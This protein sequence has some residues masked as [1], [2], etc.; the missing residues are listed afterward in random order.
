MCIRDRAHRADYDAEVL[1]SIWQ[2]MLTKLTEDDQYLTHAALAELKL[3]QAALQYL[4]PAHATVYVKNKDGLRD[5]YKLVSVSHTEFSTD[6][7]KT[8]RSMLLS[9]PDPISK[10][11]R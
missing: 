9:H 2:A 11:S 6:I 4:W 5:L 8:P 7:P 3:T 1:N 10:L